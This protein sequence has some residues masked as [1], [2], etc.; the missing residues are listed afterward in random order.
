MILSSL[1]VLGES[2]LP[3]GRLLVA[4]PMT[5]TLVPLT[6]KRMDLTL[7]SLAKNCILRGE[8]FRRERAKGSQTSDD[9]GNHQERLEVDD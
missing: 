9:H 7:G 4:C 3:D 6:G 8:D 2:C 5:E 1:V